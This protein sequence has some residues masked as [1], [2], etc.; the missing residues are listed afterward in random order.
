[1]RDVRK[2]ALAAILISSCTAGMA[3]AEHRSDF[4]EELAG[5]YL[6]N[7]EENGVIMQLS[8]DGNMLLIFS[9]EFLNLGIIGESF[10]D[11]LGSWKK[12]GRRKIVVETV[13][14]AFSDLFLGIAAVTYRIRFDRHYRQAKL[15]CK[16]AI[17]APGVD[18][19]APG[20]EPIPDSAFECDELTLRRLPK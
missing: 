15:E 1:M 8:S 11:T 3:L 10:S 12:A 13:N 17:Y 5:T 14:I 6:L 2:H 7:S 19:Y 16:G 4:G 18:P 20:A 9:E